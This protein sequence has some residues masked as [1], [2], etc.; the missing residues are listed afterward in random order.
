M[1]ARVGYDETNLEQLLGEGGR[2][3]LAEG[4]ATLAL[5][6]DADAPALVLARLFL[7]GEEIDMARAAAAL[8]PLAPADLTDIISVR[9]GVVR[10]RV[11]IETFEGL[12][13]ASDAAY[14][15]RNAVLGIGG[16]T[17]MLAALTVRRTVKSALDLCTGSGAHAF[18]AA[19]HAEHTVGVDLNPRALKLARLNAALNASA[20]IE[21]RRGDFFE[22]VAGERF[23]LVTANPPFV[24][25]PSHEFLFR[26]GAYEDDELSAAVVRGAATHLRDGG[27]AHVLCNWIAPADGAWSE[28][29]RV[30]LRDSGCDALLLRYRSESPIS[31]AL[32]WNLIPGRSLKDAA[33]MAKPW[34]AYYRARG[35]E[36]IVTGAILLRRRSGRNWVHEDELVRTPAGAAADHIERLFAGQDALAALENE[37]ELLTL[38][39]A[40][41]PGTMLVERRRPSGELDRVRLTVEEGIP[42][43]GRI[44]SACVAVL[45]GL[46]GRRALHQAIDT[47]ARDTGRSRQALTEE[48][49]PALRE[50]LARGLLITQ[51]DDPSRVT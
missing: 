38:P 32:H 9:D 21:W 3:T 42:L 35:I 28:K 10:P 2:F 44:P 4:L 1:L 22:P 17:R 7:G 43:P 37:R 12:L 14:G 15:G 51:T 24:I 45:A 29:P 30:W 26:D 41:A 50:L 5:R 33:A 46:D 19:R 27:L 39:L 47:A 36:S 13:V 34:L 25:S 8:A 6:A 31:Y 40:R 16:S 49:L 11:R 18:L 23:D 20:G 48:C